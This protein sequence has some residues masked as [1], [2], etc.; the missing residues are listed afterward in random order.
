MEEFKMEFMKKF[1][2]GIVNF[3]KNVF[4]NNVNITKQDKNIKVK[5]NLNKNKKSKIVINNNI[6]GEN[7]GEKHK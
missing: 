4:S 6:V 5:N 7:Y 2:I 3:L 1:L